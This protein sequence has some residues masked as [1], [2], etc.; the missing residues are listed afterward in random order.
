MSCSVVETPGGLHQLHVV[1]I[2]VDGGAN[3]G[4]VLEPLLLGD[5]TI[6]VSVSEVLEELK[7]DLVL[8]HFA[9]LDLGVE[10]A[11]VDVAKVG[12]SDAA[13]GVLVELVVGGQGDVLSPLVQGSLNNN[14]KRVNFLPSFPFPPS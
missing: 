1:I 13:I 4:V 12:S 9:V 8:G 10:L 3:G 2:V 5:L 6:V 11:V 7:E 14:L